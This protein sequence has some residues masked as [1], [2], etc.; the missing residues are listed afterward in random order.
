MRNCGV[1][2]NGAWCVHSRR[3]IWA[4]GPG[5]RLSLVEDMVTFPDST[6]RPYPYLRSPNAVRIAA[7][8]D[9]HVALVEQDIYLLGRRAVELPGGM[10]EQTEQPREAAARELAE[11]T[12][13]AAAELTMLGSVASAR[14]LL[15][16]T[17]TLWL[18]TGLTHGQPAPE[19]A[20]QS[21]T[22]KWV[23]IREAV[24]MAL[25]GVIVDAASAALLLHLHARTEPTP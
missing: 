9:R 7:V 14:S 2:S 21:L 3:D 17:V 22:T 25:D 20:E 23:L 4:G 5:Q 1:Q 6:V 11:E 12:G 18:A 19:P 24:R 16:E 15:T 13:V 8:E 10:V